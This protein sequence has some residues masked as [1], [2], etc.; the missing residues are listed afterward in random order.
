MNITAHVMQNRYSVGKSSIH[1]DSKGNILLNSVKD[2]NPPKGSQV[3]IDNS[4]V[5]VLSGVS[6]LGPS[7][8]N[9]HLQMNNDG[10]MF[11]QTSNGG[12]ESLISIGSKK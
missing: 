7:A 3:L 11:L 2:E 4:K 12:K 1:A 6:Q 5:E 10:T 8:N 9:C